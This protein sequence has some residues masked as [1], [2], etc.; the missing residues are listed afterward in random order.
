MASY[1]NISNLKRKALKCAV[2]DLD[3]QHNR[4]DAA[5]VYRKW[6]VFHNEWDFKQAIERK[7]IE[8]GNKP[9]N[10]VSNKK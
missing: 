10:E 5:K 1:N 7:R 2:K 8:F 3:N 4:A 6:E 9:N